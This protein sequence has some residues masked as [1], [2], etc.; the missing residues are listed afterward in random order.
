[1]SANTERYRKAATDALKTL[2]WCI[3]YFRHEG[4]GA[5]AERLERNRAY[6]RMNLTGEPEETL[7]A[8]SE[9]LP[10]DKESILN[11]VRR[12]LDAI[13]LRAPSRKPRRGRE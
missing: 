11:P 3:F 5:I 12:A 9:A 7:Q 8:V 13:G 10:Q 2:D 4:H 6:I 1:M